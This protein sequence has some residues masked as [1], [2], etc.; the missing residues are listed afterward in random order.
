MF[1]GISGKLRDGDWLGRAAFLKR[2]SG[3]GGYIQQ[4][5]LPGRNGT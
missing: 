5:G 3:L 4:G 1:T 2:C